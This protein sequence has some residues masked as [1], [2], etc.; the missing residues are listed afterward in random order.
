M[1][2]RNLYN[3]RAAVRDFEAADLESM[4]RLHLQPPIDSTLGRLDHTA[5]ILLDSDSGQT[6]LIGK[7]MEVIYL[8]D[9]LPVSG[10]LCALAQNFS[11]D[12]SAFFFVATSRLLKTFQWGCIKVTNNEPRIWEAKG[13]FF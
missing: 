5:D 6:P 11:L 8:C 4:H 7:Y 2:L 10:N 3:Q 13:T 1:N 9:L 12:E